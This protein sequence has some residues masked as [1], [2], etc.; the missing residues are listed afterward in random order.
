MTIHLVGSGPSA[1]GLDPV[2]DSFVTEVRERG[3]EPGP[4]VVCL[5]VTPDDGDLDVR[6]LLPGYADPIT[7]RWPEATFEV[8]ELRPNDAFLANPSFET[9]PERHTPDDTPTT[10]DAPAPAPTFPDLTRA[11]AIIVGG[12][13]TPGYLHSL[14]PHRDVIAHA[15]RRGLPYLGF[16]AGASIASRHALVGGEFADG[17][18]VQQDYAAEDLHDLTV[19]DGLAL[20]STLVQVHTDEWSNEGIVISALERNLAGHA[21]SIDEG[22]ALVVEPSSGRTHRLGRGRL[23]WFSKEAHGVLV[24]TEEPPT[25]PTLP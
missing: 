20:I 13:W 7:S 16:S 9:T 1:D 24:R 15:V 21:V 8:V 19:T 17:I 18:R 2:W 22:T 11:A 4:I 10:D 5:L 25:A 14:T 6:D 23:R 12:G 3:G